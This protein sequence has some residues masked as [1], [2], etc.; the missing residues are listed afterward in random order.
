MTMTMFW[1]VLLSSNGACAF[2]GFLLGRVTRATI[3]IEEHVMADTEESLPAPVRTWKLWPPSALQVIAGFV[4]V[5]GLLTVGLGVI[6]TRNQ[7]R[8]AGCVAGYSTALADA[9]DK[10]ARPQQE[11]TEQLD[12]VMLAIVNAYRTQTSEDAAKVRSAIEQYVVAREHAKDVLRR[13]PLPDAPRDAC[14]EL[15]D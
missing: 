13:N 10:R 14:A 5:V 3:A 4:A 2:L 9:L 6:V 8:L 7:D 15:L 11:A 12:K 1:T